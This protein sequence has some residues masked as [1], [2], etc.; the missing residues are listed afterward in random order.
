MKNNPKFTQEDIQRFWQQHQRFL[1]TNLT[2]ESANALTAN[3]SGLCQTNLPQAFNL[4]KQVELN[5][6][7]ALENYIPLIEQLQ[8]HLHQTL[9]LGNKVYLIGCGSSGRLAILLERLYGI[10][11][12]SS[13]RRI[14]GINAAG[15]VALVKSIEQFEDHANFGVKQLIQQG[16]TPHDLIIGLSAS[17]ESPF[18]LQTLEYALTTSTIKPWLIFNNDT[19]SLLERNPQHIAANPSLNLLSLNV[20]AMA[21]TGSTRLQATT[22]MQIALGIALCNTHTNIHR[23]IEEIYHIIEDVPLAN[24]APITTIEQ[25]IIA[26]QQ[27]ILYE[28]NDALLGLSLLA[29]T[30]E[31]SPTFNLAQ[32]EN[33]TPLNGDKKHSDLTKSPSNPSIFYLSL[34]N[35]TSAATAW[36][37]LLARAPTCLEWQNFPQTSRTYFNGFD[38]SAASLRRRGNYLPQMQ[39]SEAW[40]LKNNHLHIKLNNSETHFILPHDL[41]RQTLVY[42]LLLNSHSTLMLGALGY[43]EGNMMLSLTPSNFKLIDRAIR[44]SQFILQQQY[45]LTIDYNTLA[46]I[47]FAEIENLRPGESIVKKVVAKFIS[48]RNHQTY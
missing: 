2:T 4:F 42:K 36:N 45:S 39:H 20:G 16:Y 10:Y 29:D 34:L 27:F 40:L 1:K 12:S 38:L 41:F 35:T 13:D 43:F 3:L 11:N 18:I 24:M 9:A 22:A 44:Y 46:K 7:R 37:M 19:A 26:Q 17:G 15:D 48:H 6:I 5:A 47:T 8:Q 14:I 28:T 33:F 23:Q 32:F 25:N 21:L 30:T 31:R